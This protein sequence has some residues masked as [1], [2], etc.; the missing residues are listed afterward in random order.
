VIPGVASSWK[1]APDGKSIDF[2]IRDNAYFHNGERVT[3]EDVVFSIQH[4]VDPQTKHPYRSSYFETLQGAD[5]VSPNVVR[6]L[7][8]RPWPG[9]FD[10]LAARGHIVP[11]QYFLKV[12]AEEF[13]KKPI[14]SGPYALA[15]YRRG[16]RMELQAMAN[17][18][19]GKPYFDKL[20]WRSVPDVNT[21]V[22]MLCS[23][24]ADA[25]TD[26]QPSLLQTIRDCGANAEVLKG[27]HQR[28]LIMNTLNGG[29]LADRRV[30]IA[31]NLAID[32]KA[33]FDAIFGADVERVNGALSAYHVGGKAVGP[34]PYDPEQAKKLLAEAGYPNGFSTDLIY[35]S[36]RYVDEGELLPSLVSYWK[37]IGVNVTTRSVEYNQW[38]S[39]AGKKSY[40]GLFSYSKGAGTIADPTSAFDRHVM[41]DALYSAYCNREL[42]AIV[43]SAAGVIDESKLEPIFAKAQKISHDDP[44]A[45][46][47]YDLP[48]MFG[49]K[50]GLR[51]LGEYG[52]LEQG[53]GWNY[54]TK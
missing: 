48:T 5:L 11:K 8:S 40:S 41:C 30:R 25:I 44:P 50:K 53:G 39:F 47:L 26:I 22:A 36:G 49:W 35:T 23:G 54:L 37:K 29:P 4:I 27:I 46:F 13:A 32:R 15:N 9:T 34:Y 52:V 33:V 21:R 6:L 28:F 24:E 12:G 1:V 20:T 7:Y 45:V 3:A 51:W 31:L 19:G 18:W 17:Y 42:D 10:A 38:I 16:D 14:G 2:T 43:K